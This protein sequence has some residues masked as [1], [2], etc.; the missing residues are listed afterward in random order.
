M[1]VS[2]APAAR[3][4]GLP[5]WV[6]VL[7]VLLLLPIACV[8]WLMPAKIQQIEPGSEAPRA[9]DEPAPGR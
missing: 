7:L 3:R 1:P 2:P 9:A 8:V 4:R 6:V 5:I